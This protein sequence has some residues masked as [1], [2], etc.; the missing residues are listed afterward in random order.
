MEFKE[1][2]PYLLTAIGSGGLGTII[3]A[4]I[5][6]KK[7]NADVVSTSADAINTAIGS[8]ATING[9]STERIVSLETRI[10]KQDEIIAALREENLKL[11]EELFAVKNGKE[12]T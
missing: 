2:I 3:L 5:G 12:S 8:W 10:A 7:T 11:K 1:L 9:I 4:L 6:R